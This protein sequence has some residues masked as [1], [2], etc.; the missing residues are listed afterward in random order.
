MTV[1]ICKSEP[2]QN[3]AACRGATP[4]FFTERGVAA[5]RGVAKAKA[6]CAQCPV[7]EPCLEGALER[8]E[9]FGV[10]GGLTVKE[11][12]RMIR[13]TVIRQRILAAAS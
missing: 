6:T 11:R 12:Q 10:W 13:A 8:R 2:W 9:L 5:Q 7:S 4:V 3:Q 1:G